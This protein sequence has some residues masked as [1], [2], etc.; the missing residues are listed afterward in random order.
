MASQSTHQPPSSPSSP[1]LLPVSGRGSKQ[2]KKAKRN[3]QHRTRSRNPVK[4]GSSLQQH[5]PIKLLRERPPPGALAAASNKEVQK[6]FLAMMGLI[7]E[8]IDIKKIEDMSDE[9]ADLIACAN[10]HQFSKILHK[11]KIR[12]GYYIAEEKE[13]ALVKFGKY[14]GKDN[15]DDEIPT[16]TCIA[17]QNMKFFTGRYEEDFC[18]LIRTPENMNNNDGKTFA[19]ALINIILFQ[20]GRTKYV[21]K[22]TEQGTE[23]SVSYILIDTATSEKQSFRGW[24]DFCLTDKDMGPGVTLVS[25]GEVESNDDCLAQ[26]GIY[27]VGQLKKMKS[28]RIACIAIYRQKR[29]N[30]GICSITDDDVISFKLANTLSSI[31]LTIPEGI[32]SFANLLCATLDYVK[33]D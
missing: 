2:R 3:N 23:Y 27:G 11:H 17:H 32:K 9:S 13:E 12:D 29:G 24:P 19:V 10:K 16:C 20:T 6:K 14:E 15:S 25:V 8:G 26:L 4:T 18:E 1:S 7:N 28:K 30:I 22:P 31:D 5:G 21:I 33:S